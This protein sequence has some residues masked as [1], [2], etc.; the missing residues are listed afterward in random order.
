MV[1][2]LSVPLAFL[3]PTAALLL[4]LLVIPVEMVI[5]RRAPAGLHDSLRVR[6]G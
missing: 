3:T 5:A 4:W 6:G 2:M 1:F